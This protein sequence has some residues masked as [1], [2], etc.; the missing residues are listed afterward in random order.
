MRISVATLS[1]LAL[2]LALTSVPLSAQSICDNV[3]GNLITNCG[4]ESGD[5]TA[6]P[7]AG[8]YLRIYQPAIRKQRHLRRRVG[9]EEVDG[10]LSQTFNGNGYSLFDVSFWL[11]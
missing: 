4:F 11:L 3:A 6:G 1:V 7:P 8:R 9:T 5:F 2:L 10:Y